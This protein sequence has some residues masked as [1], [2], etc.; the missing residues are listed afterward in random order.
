MC[1]IAGGSEWPVFYCVNFTPIIHYNQPFLFYH[2]KDSEDNQCQRKR[3]GGKGD[4]EKVPC[5]KN[6]DM[7][8]ENI[9]EEKEKASD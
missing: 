5:K 9:E 7:V 6:K 3:K 1:A 4:G 2:R 8:I